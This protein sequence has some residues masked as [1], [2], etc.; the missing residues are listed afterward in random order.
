[1]YY[2][3][4]DVVKRITFPEHALLGADLE[5]AAYQVELSVNF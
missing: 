5:E 4:P 3:Q 2:V 1:M